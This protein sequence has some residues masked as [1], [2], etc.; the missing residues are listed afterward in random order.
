MA[1]D[2]LLVL[3]PLIGMAGVEWVAHPFQHLLVEPQ[4]PEQFGEPRFERFGKFSHDRWM[5]R[6]LANEAE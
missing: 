5:K 6:T 3:S 2:R 4:P 1:P